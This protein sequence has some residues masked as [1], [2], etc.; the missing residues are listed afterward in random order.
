MIRMQIRI[1]LDS[2]LGRA[3]QNRTWDRFRLM[4]I[5]HGSVDMQEK[6]LIMYLSYVNS[7]STCNAHLMMNAKL[8]LE[9]PQSLSSVQ[10][11][12]HFRLTMCIL[13]SQKRS[14]D[15]L[16]LSH[17]DNLGA[18]RLPLADFPAAVDYLLLKM[19]GDRELLPNS[20]LGRYQAPLWM[21]SSYMSNDGL[22]ELRICSPR[23]C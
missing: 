15:S 1:L 10:L 5:K 7:S 17:P 20:L 13:K 8:I 9:N 4:N 21:F 6:D 16:D 18:M 19:G 11:L 23:M 3:C 2:T 14:R 22:L 12:Y